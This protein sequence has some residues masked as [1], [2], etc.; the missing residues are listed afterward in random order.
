M[1][2]TAKFRGLVGGLKPN[3]AVGNDSPIHVDALFDLSTGADDSQIRQKNK[4]LRAVSSNDQ[5]NPPPPHPPPPPPTPTPPPP[6]PSRSN[7]VSCHFL[8]RPPSLPPCGE[9]IVKSNKQRAESREQRAESREKRGESS[10]QRA[11]RAE[12]SEQRGESREERG[13]SSREERGERIEGN[14]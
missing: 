14:N 13:E 11:E 8:C 2:G 7:N 5:P 9:S 1:A 3:V 12:S 4:F 10:E 6:P